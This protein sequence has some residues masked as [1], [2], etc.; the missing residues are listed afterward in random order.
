M[1]ELIEIVKKLE[2]RKNVLEKSVKDYML[3]NYS[4][5]YFYNKKNNLSVFKMLLKN[6]WK[7]RL[8]NFDFI[9]ERL[10]IKIDDTYTIEEKRNILREQVNYLEEALLKTK[11]VDLAKKEYE[12]MQL[13]KFGILG[14]IVVAIITPSF[15]SK[16]EIKNE[17]TTSYSYSSVKII[18]NSPW[19]GTVK[20][21]ERYLKDNLKDPDSYD[22]IEWSKVQEMGNGT[23]QVRHKYR[24]KNGFGGYV[25]SN[26]IFVLNGDGEV[27][28]VSEF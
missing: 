26:K 8:K 15:F 4:I 19:D 22:G 7:D 2:S 17:P 1:N 18:E 3:K 14:L 24:A 13:V 5:Y 23:Y 12:R 27:I 9:K 20:Q 16:N 6:D 25:V 11:E 21:V 10:N 28:R